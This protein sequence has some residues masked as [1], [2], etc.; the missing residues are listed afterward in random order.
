MNK[1]SKQ[2]AKQITQA[3]LGSQADLEKEIS[4]GRLI[5]YAPELEIFINKGSEKL[6][7]VVKASEDLKLNP[8]YHVHNLDILD[9][10][11][12]FERATG[13]YV[14]FYKIP[15]EMK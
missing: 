14:V 1:A 12:R 2:K 10:V 13:G 9:I 6:L 15:I 4:K 5:S 8:V 11:Y 7:A 3:F